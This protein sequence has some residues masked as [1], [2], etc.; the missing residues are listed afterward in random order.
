MVISIEV[1]KVT[2]SC[3]QSAMPYKAFDLRVLQHVAIKA[4]G[5]LRVSKLLL[6]L[7]RN[8]YT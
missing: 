4:I 6:V 8:R 5:Y 2:Q 1:E 7:V 3:I